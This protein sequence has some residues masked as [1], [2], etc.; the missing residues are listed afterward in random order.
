MDIEVLK[1]SKEPLM[2]RSYFEAKI[3]FQGKTPSRIDMK[4]D[5]CKKLESK[6][7]L[8]VVRK[9]STDYGTERA[10]INGYV[11]EDE[12]TMKNIE[13]KYVLVRHL[14]KT[15]QTAEKERVKAEKQAAAPAAKKKKK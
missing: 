9:I 4:K 8:T 6:D 7:N 11:Y 3:V 14:T 1:Q 13:N 2:K 5:L 12:A 15:E 10:I